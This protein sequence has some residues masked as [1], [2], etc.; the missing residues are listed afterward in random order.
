MSMVRI[1]VVKGVICKIWPSFFR[2]KKRKKTKQKNQYQQE[3]KE[4]LM[5]TCLY[6]IAEIPCEASL[7]TILPWSLPSHNTTLEAAPLEPTVSP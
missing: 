4:T 2:K 1:L 5:V 3:C 7:L 6:C